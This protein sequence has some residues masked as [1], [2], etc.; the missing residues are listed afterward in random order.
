M[1][2]S[3]TVFMSHYVSVCLTLTVFRIVMRGK[4]HAQ[5]AS[6][7]FYCNPPCG[8]TRT[9]NYAIR[10]ETLS[11]VQ[12]VRAYRLLSSTLLSGSHTQLNESK[13]LL[14]SSRARCFC[15]KP[16]L[17]YGPSRKLVSK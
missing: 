4:D 15:S 16:K 3:N 14:L 12:R 13:K 5:R 10:V 17:R 8:P 9:T 1:D 6:L 11:Y 7:S 2:L